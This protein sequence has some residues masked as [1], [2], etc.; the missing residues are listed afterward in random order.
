MQS[1]PDAPEL[2]AAIREFLETEIVPTLTDP[3]LKFRT[4]VAMNALGMLERE[5]RLE[6]GFL[7]DECSSLA[8]L[9]N[10]SAVTPDSLET[11]RKVVLELNTRLASQIRAGGVPTGTLE[12]LKRAAIHKLRV[13][14]PGYLKR[15]A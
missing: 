14:S 1:R 9:L 3:R 5:V 13:A 4:L 10:V 15:Y 6:E 7:K 8:G 11:L 12:T 2:A